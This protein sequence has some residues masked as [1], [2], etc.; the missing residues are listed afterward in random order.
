MDT[1]RDLYDV[2]GVSKTATQEEIKKAYRKKALEFHPDRNK[3]K[4][5]EDKFKQVNEAY[6]ILSDE[7]KRKTY[8][9]FGHQAFAQGGGANPFAGGF[10]G[11][12]GPFTYTYTSQGGANPFGDFDFSDPF[13]VFESIF[14]GGFARRPQKPRYSLNIDFMEAVKGTKKTIVH[15]GKSHTVN[16]PAGADDGTRIRYQDFDVTLDVKP[17]DTFKRQGYDVIVDFDIPFTLAALGGQIEV[18]TLEKSVKLKIRPGTQP[19]TII[20]LKDQGIKHLRGNQK[21]DQYTRLIITIPK[22][23]SR[24]Q[25]SLLKQLQKTF[26]S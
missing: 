26:Q 10:S 21:G 20:R 13:E 11:R 15:Q 19:G 22:S 6:E 5:A 9:Q 16:I 1:K 24:E 17:H 23:L 18:P 3:E 8:D 25:K 7:Q 14:G 4:D 2:L 12:S